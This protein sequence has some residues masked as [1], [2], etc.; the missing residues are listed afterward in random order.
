MK[1]IILYFV[2]ACI[3]VVYWFLGNRSNTIF[4]H[5]QNFFAFAMIGHFGSM[6][7]ADYMAKKRGKELLEEKMKEFQQDLIKN[8][9]R[10]FK[11]N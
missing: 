8:I 10:H 4:M 2:C 3:L 7:Y 5:C 11:N 1:I 9:N 6:I